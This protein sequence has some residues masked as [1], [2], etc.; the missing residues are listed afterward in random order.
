MLKKF[1]RKSVA[2]SVLL[3]A[4]SSSAWAGNVTINYHCDDNKSLRVTFK[5][6]EATM[7]ASLKVDAIPR[8]LTLNSNESS[9]GISIF[10]GEEFA[11]NMDAFTMKTLRQATINTVTN[12]FGE[13]RYE[14]CEPD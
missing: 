5:P 10:E 3:V 8:T 7:R 2:C 4:L 14:N 13:A 9:D 12:E 6:G 1:T 11:M